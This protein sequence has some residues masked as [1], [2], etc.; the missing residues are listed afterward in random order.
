M[1]F[2]WVKGVRACSGSLMPTTNPQTF[3]CHPVWDNLEGCW[4]FCSL[5]Q[6]HWLLFQS[7]LST[8][9]V[10][11][12]VLLHTSEAFCP[13]LYSHRPNFTHWETDPEIPHAQN[14]IGD[15][16]ESQQHSNPVLLSWGLLL[17]SPSLWW[18]RE[19]C[20]KAASES[21]KKLWFLTRP[22]EHA[23]LGQPRCLIFQL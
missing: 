15:L 1:S 2:Y 3:L 7:L 19:V 23:C 9:R 6:S 16:W 20:F 14:H 4:H 5:L 18:R 11:R 22:E 17:H 12:L 8:C 13:Q 21:L 10:P